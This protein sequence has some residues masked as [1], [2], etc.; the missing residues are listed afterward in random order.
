MSRSNP[1]IRRDQMRL[2]ILLIMVGLALLGCDT[3]RIAPVPTEL[4]APAPTGPSPAI[5]TQ[6]PASTTGSCANLTAEACANNGEHA[7]VVTAAEEFDDC[8]IVVQVGDQHVHTNSFDAGGLY[9][10]DGIDVTQQAPNVFSWV[11]DDGEANLIT[12]TLEGYVY[13]ALHNEQAC[14]RITYAL[15]NP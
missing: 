14:L 1:C 11:G 9:L 8:E 6:T 10:I 12:F 15:V 3:Y 2:G 7:Y 5:A 13:D 4:N